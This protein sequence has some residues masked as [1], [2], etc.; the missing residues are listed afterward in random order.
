MP[1]FALMP[2]FALALVCAGGVQGCP[3]R[4][5]QAAALTLGAKRA[6]HGARAAQ[7]GGA[8]RGSAG[9]PW[10]EPLL[11]GKDLHLIDDLAQV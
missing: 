2:V 11:G 8:G 7:A 3:L 6:G 5:S 1:A 9:V 10:L 4:S